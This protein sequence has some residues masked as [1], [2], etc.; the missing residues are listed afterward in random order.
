MKTININGKAYNIVRESYGAVSAVGSV[1]A[2]ESVVVPFAVWVFGNRPILRNLSIFGAATLGTGVGLAGGVI[3]KMV[4]DSYAG[5]YNF[6]A[7]KINSRRP[8]MQ[9]PVTVE[10]VEETSE[11]DAADKP[12]EKVN[13]YRPDKD[14]LND[15]IVSSN[16]FMF[17]SESAAMDALAGAAN[18]I[19]ANGFLTVAD[20]QRNAHGFDACASMMQND[21]LFSICHTYGW[22]AT[23]MPSWFVEETDDNEWYFGA[24]NY[25]D[26]SS[27]LVVIRDGDL[28]E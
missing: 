20:F 13:V 6:I 5:V 1:F 7:D 21:K 26:I 18:V 15:Y 12:S 27:H 23:S 11:E 9:A 19:S 10:A 3:G 24:H 2:F 17:D 28:K 8:D 22:D 25:H 4:I 14:I 16:M